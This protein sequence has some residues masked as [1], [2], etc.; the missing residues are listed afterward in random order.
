MKKEEILNNIKM[1]A[2]QQ[3][4][5]GRILNTLEEMSESERNN[6]LQLLEEQNFQDVVDMV[7]YFEC[8]GK[9]EKNFN[10]LK[11]LSRIGVNQYGNK[12]YK[13]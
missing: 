5:Y 10:Y 12:N 11:V 13:M 7:M 4:F 1:L 3:G 2:N 6:V 8:Q 9:T